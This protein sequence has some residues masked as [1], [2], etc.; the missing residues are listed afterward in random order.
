MS[1]GG[2]KKGTSYILPSSSIRHFELFGGEYA[3]IKQES[4]AL[5]GVAYF[6]ISGHGGRDPGAVGT[7]NGKPLHEDEYAYDVM[8]RVARG[9]MAH[10]A[11]VFVMV[12]DDPIRD[13]KYLEPDQDE[14]NID[15]TPVSRDRRVK[16]RVEMVNILARKSSAR[17]KRVVEIHVDARDQSSTQVDVHFYYNSPA[18]RKLSTILRDTMRDQYKLAQPNRGYYGKVSKADLYTLKYTNPVATYVELGNIHHERD[19]RR[20][21]EPGNRQAIADWMVLGFIKESGTSTSRS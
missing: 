19:Q 4:G 8:L 6:L 16:E 20:I 5:K 1:D 9:L 15:G 21:I 18:G 12:Q 10:G 14:K 2:L 3:A 13:E 11:E 17:V 7:R